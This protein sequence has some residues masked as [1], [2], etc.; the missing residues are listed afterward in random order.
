MQQRLLAIVTVLVP[1][2]AYAQPTD[3]PIVPAEAPA[4]DVHRKT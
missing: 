4:A 2:L 3:A 1:G